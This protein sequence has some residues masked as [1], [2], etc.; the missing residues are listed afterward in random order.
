MRFFQVKQSVGKAFYKGL[1][2]TFSQHRN[3][4]L[5]CGIFRPQNIVILIKNFVNLDAIYPLFCI[6]RPFCS[7]SRHFAAQ[8]H[9]TTPRQDHSAHKAADLSHLTAPHR[10]FAPIRSI[11]AHSAP[12]ST[13]LWDFRAQSRRLVTLFFTILPLCGTMT[14]LCYTKGQFA[15]QNLSLPHCSP[16]YAHKRALFTTAG[17]FGNVFS[18]KLGKTALCSHKNT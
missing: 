6:S 5:W 4:V 2:H 18:S 12:F 14:P 7:T 11:F 10:P 8:R 3:N 16:S 1:F 13:D 15:P 9:I 17:D